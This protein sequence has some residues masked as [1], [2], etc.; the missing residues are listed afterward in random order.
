MRMN[1]IV[2]IALCGLFITPYPSHAKDLVPEDVVHEKLH[3]AESGINVWTYWPKKRPAAKLPCVLIAAAGS[4]LYHGMSLG[5]GDMPEHVPYAQA[6]FFVIAYDVSGPLSKQA[7]EKA[8]RK[9]IRLF[10]DSKGGLRDASSALEL[11]LKKYD[12]I[13]RERVFAVGH[14]SAGTIAL[15]V[16]ENLP[17][18][19]GCVA[20]APIADIE[21]RCLGFLGF[22]IWIIGFLD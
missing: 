15:W 4:R 1:T 2:L 7:P 14:S 12:F 13:D 18:V 11:A 17:K 9:A 5:E 3:V 20:Y 8:K 22:S 10:M 6:G 16:A 19:Q 21:Q